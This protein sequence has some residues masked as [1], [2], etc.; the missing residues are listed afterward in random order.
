MESEFIAIDSQYWLF[1]AINHTWLKI[2]T[3]NSK[4]FK[5]NTNYHMNDKTRQYW[6]MFVKSLQELTTMNTVS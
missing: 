1:I 4:L 3:I 5:T 2:A 6:L